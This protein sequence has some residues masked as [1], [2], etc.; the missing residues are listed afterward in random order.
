MF[1]ESA[2]FPWL[3]VER[4]V[5]LALQLRHVAKT[6]RRAKVAELLDW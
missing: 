1:Q 6:E 5:E 2:L 4:N 3:T